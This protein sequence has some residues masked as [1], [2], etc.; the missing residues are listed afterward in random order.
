MDELIEALRNYVSELD[1]KNH[2]MQLFMKL[3]RLRKVLYAYDIIA[4]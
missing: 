3:R 1:F 4:I 2:R